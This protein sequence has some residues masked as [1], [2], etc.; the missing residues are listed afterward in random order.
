MLKPLAKVPWYFTLSAKFPP[1]L[2]PENPR[3]LLGEKPDIIEAS[4]PSRFT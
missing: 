2:N 4:T 3:P 1:G